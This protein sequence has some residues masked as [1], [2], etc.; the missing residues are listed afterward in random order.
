MAKIHDAMPHQHK[1]ISEHCGGDKKLIEL[2]NG[3]C[4]EGKIKCVKV[5]SAGRHG[6][7]YACTHEQL[8]KMVNN[9]PKKE[10]PVPS[11]LTGGTLPNHKTNRSPLT[12]G[13]RRKTLTKILA[14]LPFIVG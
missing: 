2:L 10:K 4:K 11:L 9:N 12:L 5:R 1:S 14:L 6:F 7:K 8:P 13:E 3:L